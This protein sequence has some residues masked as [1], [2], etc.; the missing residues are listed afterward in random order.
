MCVYICAHINTYTFLLFFSFHDGPLK[1]STDL[2]QFTAS[3]RLSVTTLQIGSIGSSFSSYCSHG[4]FLCAAGSG[5]GIKSQTSTESIP[6]WLPSLTQSTLFWTWTA[7]VQKRHTVQ[8]SI[9]TPFSLDPRSH[10]PQ[11]SPPFPGTLDF[12]SEACSVVLV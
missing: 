1:L 9:K 5:R 12:P 6:P 8:R 3:I 2:Q 10:L 4:E 7:Q 11:I